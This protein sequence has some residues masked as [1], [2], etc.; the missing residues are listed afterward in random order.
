MTCPISQ[1]NKVSRRISFPSTRGRR[2]RGEIRFSEMGEATECTTLRKSAFGR[3][4]LFVRSPGTAFREIRC[5]ASS[6][7][8]QASA[9][10]FHRHLG[11]QA[12]QKPCH[13]VC[14]HCCHPYEGVGFRLP[15]LFDPSDGIYHV[16]GWYCSA[17]CAKA[18]ILEHSSFDRGYQMN[19]FIRM[20]RDV[21]GIHETVNE[22]PPRLS[23]SMFG[24]PFDITSFR[25]TTNICTVLT[26]PFV[27][28]CM[29][30]EERTPIVNIGEA[31]AVQQRGSVRGLRRPTTSFAAPACVEDDMCA[32][33][34]G[35]DGL[36]ATYLKSKAQESD[37]HPSKRTRTQ[38]VAAS[39]GQGLAKFATSGTK[40]S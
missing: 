22:A 1:T 6:D 26:P 19:I 10:I 14:W 9:S 34:V 32:P 28:Y 27:S 15:R 23:L 29:L 37:P 30:I 21:Y 24:G 3:T 36:Y 20:L 16:Y 31:P 25:A 4:D 33:D 7:A 17:N 38:S 18:Y 8:R 12:H 13:C 40:T 11:N 39:S 2:Q 5:S 35:D